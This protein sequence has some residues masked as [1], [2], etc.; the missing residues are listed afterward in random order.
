MIDHIQPSGLAPA[1]GQYAQV[2]HDPISGIVFVAGQVAIDPDGQMVGVGDV[3]AQ[4]ERTFEN[5]RVALEGAGSSLGDT[6]KLMTYLVDPAHLPAFRET[7]TRLFAEYF[8]DGRYPAHTLVIVAGLSAPEHLI[9][10]EAVAVRR[11]A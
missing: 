9:E 4:T 5:I 11:P 6:L 3:A 10:I 2:T 8:P 7:R 1:L